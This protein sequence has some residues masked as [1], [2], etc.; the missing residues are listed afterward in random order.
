MKSAY[1]VKEKEKKRTRQEREHNIPSGM[2]PAQQIAYVNARLD[3]AQ[4]ELDEQ[5]GGY[6][7]CLMLTILWYLHTAPDLRFGKKRLERAYKAL[8]EDRARQR[9]DM[10]DR[11]TDKFGR[12]ILDL[13]APG[14]HVEDRYYRD[15]LRAIG[16]D[17]DEWEE[18][19]YWIDE[20]KGVIGWRNE[21]KD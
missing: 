9:A 10:R 8:V 12:E 7:D 14:Q 3:K 4:R 2:N 17:Y 13:A 6:W 18:R 11:G 16:F 21:K 20:K 15:Q 5:R 19:A 1:D